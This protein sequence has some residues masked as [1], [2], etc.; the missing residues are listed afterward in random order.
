[1]VIDCVAVC[2]DSF[3]C[4]AGMPDETCF[5]SSFGGIISTRLALPLKVYARPG[6]CNYT[7]YLQVKKVIEQHQHKEH[8]PLVLVSLTN[9]SRL[10]FPINSTN[11]DTNPNLASVDYLSYTPYSKHSRRRREIPFAQNPIPNY[12]S[13]TISNMGLCLAGSHLK[14]EA[15]YSMIYE[16]KWKAISMYFE[17]LYDDGIKREYDESLVVMM[18]VLL[19]EHGIPHVILGHGRYTFRHIPNPHFVDIHWGEISS[20]HPDKV[21]SGHCDENG[22]RIVAERLLGP[23]LVQLGNGPA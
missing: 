11:L 20:K 12:T 5:E 18:H 16:R 10:I 9:H 14:K 7:I 4:G 8:S 19:K 3:A 23:C 1:M 17:E 22:H 13:E 2:G 21:N 15:N 6:C